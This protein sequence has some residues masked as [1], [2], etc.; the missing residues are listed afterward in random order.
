MSAVPKWRRATQVGLAAQI[1]GNLIGAA[2]SARIATTGA[3]GSVHR[4]NSFSKE[5]ASLRRENTTRSLP[6]RIIVS[7]REKEATPPRLATPQ[8]ALSSLNLS[9]VKVNSLSPTHR[10]LHGN[11]ARRRSTAGHYSPR[12]DRCHCGSS[13]SAYWIWTRTISSWQRK[14][15]SSTAGS[16]WRARPSFR[17]SKH[18]SK[19]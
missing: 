12:G 14:K 5:A 1:E 15:L 6:G 10:R 8:Q 19:G 3:E 7:L 9:F 4:G 16:K 13:T 11:Q 18:C 17:I 2:Q